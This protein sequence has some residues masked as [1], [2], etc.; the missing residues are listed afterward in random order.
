MVW[1]PLRGP[2]EKQ[3]GYIVTTDPERAKWW[4]RFYEAGFDASDK[5]S[6]AEYIKAQE[7]ARLDHEAWLAGQSA[8]TAPA[9]DYSE[10]AQHLS[11]P[12][13]AEI[14]SGVGAA[15]P[16]AEENGKAAREAI[17]K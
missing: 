12:S 10:L 9:I 15:V 3:R 4:T 2:D 1:P 7:M 13:V 14:V 5:F 16:S 17:V 11:I 6:R 8:L